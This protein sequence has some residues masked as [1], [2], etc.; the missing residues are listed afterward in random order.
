MTRETMAETMRT[1]RV[2]SLKLPM[3][4]LSQ[5]SASGSGRRLE[6]KTSCRCGTWDKGGGRE[7]G[8]S[9][10]GERGAQSGRLQS[11]IPQACETKERCPVIENPRGLEKKGAK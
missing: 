10:G 9:A 3:K 2:A 5:D 11:L 1:I 6:P 7:G 4:M 8:A